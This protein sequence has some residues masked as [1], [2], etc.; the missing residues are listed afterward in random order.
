MPKILA[1]I[2]DRLKSLGEALSRNPPRM[3]G[4]SDRSIEAL[5]RRIEA[6]ESRLGRL[7][8]L[9][10]LRLDKLAEVRRRDVT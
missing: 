1:S 6:V 3:P 10:E 8:N 4:W 7:D 2:E 9:M 5:S